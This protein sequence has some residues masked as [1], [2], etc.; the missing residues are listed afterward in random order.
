MEKAYVNARRWLVT[1]FS[2]FDMGLGKMEDIFQAFERFGAFRGDYLMSL[3]DYNLAV[4]QLD[5]SSGAYRR[6]LPPDSK[7]QKDITPGQAVQPVS[8]PAP[9][10]AK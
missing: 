10:K 2:N 1:S 6:N 9:V 4:A 7:P 8:A 5:K 3:F